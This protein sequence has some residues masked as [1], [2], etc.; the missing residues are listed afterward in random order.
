M[1]KGFIGNLILI[2]VGLIIAAALIGY[3]SRTVIQN[4]NSTY[5]VSQ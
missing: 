1:N 5:T 2:V 3:F 4:T